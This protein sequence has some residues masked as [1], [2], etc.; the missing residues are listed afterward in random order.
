MK[1]TLKKCSVV[2]PV[3]KK[4]LQEYEI[5]SFRQCLKVLNRR[6]IILVTYQESDLSVYYTIA[7][8]CKKDISVQYF[9][10]SYFVDISSYNKL[11][12]SLQFYKSFR[13]YEYIL[14]YQ[15]DSFVFRDELDY[16]CQL[17]YDY[18][19]APWFDDFSEKREDTDLW[20][21]G[22][23]GFSLRRI[24][25]FIKVLSW[26]LPLKK[27]KINSLLKF[28]E[29]KKIL[30]VIGWRNNIY[31]FIKA[32]PINEDVFFTNFL[33]DTYLEPYLP[34]VETAIRFAFEKSP[35]YL[36]EQNQQKLPMGC[37][38]F[39]KYEYDSFWKNF[40]KEE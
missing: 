5:L 21:V 36:Y 33:Y 39:L 3:Y 14:I 32:N 15:L 17:G 30:Y 24:S 38:A 31:Y 18:I 16:W 22:N 2:I 4:N 8:E 12:K 20:R 13:N 40:I 19:G 29:I 35:R 34:P 27:I 23:G 25:F 37:H 6:D 10:S 1:G 11:M 28:Q 7:K 26:K 9:D